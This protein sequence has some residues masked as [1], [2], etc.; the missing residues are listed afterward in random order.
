MCGEKLDSSS[1]RLEEM[2]KTTLLIE[3]DK[4]EAMYWSR[5]RA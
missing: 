5:E 1:S 4:Q 3:E 2:R